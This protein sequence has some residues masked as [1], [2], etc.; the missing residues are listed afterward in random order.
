MRNMKPGM[1]EYQAESLFR[2]Y[3][4]YNYGCRLMGYTPICGCGPSG[5]ILH[6][7]HSGEPN[8]H[9]SSDGDICLFDMGAEYFGYGSD[10]TCSFPI[11]CTFTA[12]QKI[13]Y[14]AVLNAQVAVYAM[15][16]PGVSWVDCHKVAE[17]E[18]LKGLMVAGVVVVPGE[19]SSSSSSLT[20]LLDE[21]V[22]MR[23]AAVFMPHGLGHFIGIDTHDVGGYLPGHAERIM[24]PGLKSLRTARVLKENMVL[25]VE[26][27]CYFIQHL[28]EQALQN[29]LFLPYLN[30]TKIDEYRGVGGVRLE[31][32]VQVISSGIDNFT[33]CP[34][35]IAEVE[36]VMA[37]GKWPPVKDEAPELK[38]TRLTG[39]TPLP[40]PPSL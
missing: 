22:E 20:N 39:P 25:T 9:Q 27:G 7:G 11:N 2:H 1:Y 6:Y 32:V 16:Q 40:S 23:L 19:S 34:R 36:A 38:R 35:T 10:V 4:Y 33:L 3:C 26:P 18:I 24:Q 37:G 21:L 29:E 17:R 13:I 30:A 8:A 28:L 5:A 14:Q 15:M 31:D 12:S